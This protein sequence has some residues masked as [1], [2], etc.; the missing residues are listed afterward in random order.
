MSPRH[1]LQFSA[2][3]INQWIS[4]FFPSAGNEFQLDPS[5]EPESSNPDPDK[6]ATFAILQRYNR[7]NL[8]IPVGAPHCYHAAM[9]SKALRLIALGEHYRQLSEKELI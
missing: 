1:N 4:E 2:F 7:V 9:E 6:T 3:P 8:L 5:Y